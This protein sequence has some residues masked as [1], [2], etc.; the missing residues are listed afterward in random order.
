MLVTDPYQIHEDFW[1]WTAGALH[2]PYSGGS[3][4]VSQYLDFPCMKSYGVLGDIDSIALF[5]D[6]SDYEYAT[7]SSA[8]ININIKSGRNLP[9]GQGIQAFRL[10]K[11]WRIATTP[12]GLNTSPTYDYWT[13]NPVEILWDTPG[14]DIDNTC[15][16]TA[17]TASI[18]GPMELSIDITPIAIMYKGAFAPILVRVTNTSLLG[19]M[20][21]DYEDFLAPTISYSGLFGH[22]GDDPCDGGEGV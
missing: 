17:Y 22:G 11:H 13:N 6:L 9:S 18:S 5:V 4:I 12:G 2:I 1:G 8:H 10:L 19:G 7:I 3:F 20:Q 14:G 15:K 21:I 16:G